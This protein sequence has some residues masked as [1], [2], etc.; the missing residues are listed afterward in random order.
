MAEIAFREALRMTLREELLADKRVVFLGEDIGAYG[1]SYAVTKGFLDEFGPQRIMDTPISEEVI[2]GCAIG[3]AMGG[4]RPMVELMTINFS[5][6]A[7]DQ[8]VNNAAKISYM[9]GGQY[10]VPLV[11]RMA[12]GAGSQLSRLCECCAPSWLPAPPA[13]RI[14][15]GTLIWPFDM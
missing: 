6:L 12:R 15:S 2:V 13:M 7:F 10:H 4:L 8:I 3:A 1:G 11:M 9:S 14:T 5:L